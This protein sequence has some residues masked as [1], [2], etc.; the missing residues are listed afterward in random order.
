MTFKCHST[1]WIVALSTLKS[2]IFGWTINR[3]WLQSAIRQLESSL[4]PLQPNLILGWTRSRKLA[5]SALQALEKLLVWFHPS[6]IQVGPEPENKLKGLCESLKHRF[7]DL[8]Q[9]AFWD[10]VETKWFQRDMGALETTPSRHHPS[11]I[12]ACSIGRK[13]VP[14]AWRHLKHRFLDLNKVEFWGCL[15]AEK[16]FKDMNQRIFDFTEIA[17]SAVHNAGNELSLP[18]N[19]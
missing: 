18:C 6:L 14:S 2:R 11:S 1:S 8:N 9:F 15:E 3:K 16:D 4:F 10:G 5:H 12:L 13:W 17:F 7:F 19:Y